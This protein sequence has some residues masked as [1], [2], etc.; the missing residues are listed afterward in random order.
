MYVPVDPSLRWAVIV[1]DWTTPH[2]HHM[3]PITKV[4]FE[5]KRVYQSCTKANGSITSTVLNIENGNFRRSMV[6]GFAHTASAP[7]TKVI[8]NGKSIST[9][10]PDLQSKRAKSRII[11]EVRKDEWP[12][13]LGLKGTGRVC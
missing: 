8:V 13:G 2:N 4:S 5:A 3:L 7:S 1:P 6:S 12:K 10:H 11:A 9:V